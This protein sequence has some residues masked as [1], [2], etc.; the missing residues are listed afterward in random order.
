MALKPISFLT[1]RFHFL[2]FWFPCLYLFEFLYFTSSLLCNASQGGGHLYRN[3]LSFSSL[4]NVWTIVISICSQIS[5]KTRIFSNSLSMS[6]FKLYI[7]RPVY[8]IGSGHLSNRISPIDLGPP[9][10]T[11]SVH[12]GQVSSMTF[13]RPMWAVFSL[14]C[15]TRGTHCVALGGTRLKPLTAW[16]PSDILPVFVGP[17][18]WQNRRDIRCVL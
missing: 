2:A 16:S 1:V 9:D 13:T 18:L 17:R 6:D 11:V 15:Q 4:G 8:P 7:I 3:E 5:L 14:F 10:P 12:I